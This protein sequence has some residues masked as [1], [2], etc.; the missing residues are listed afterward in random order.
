MRNKTASGGG[1]ILV[2]SESEVSPQLA[3]KSLVR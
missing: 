1:S 3:L 2:E